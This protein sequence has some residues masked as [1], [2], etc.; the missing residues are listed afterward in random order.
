MAK[1]RR[2][3]LANEV[4]AGSTAEL[5]QLLPDPSKGE[6][7]KTP[8]F[9]AEL[10]RVAKNPLAILEANGEPAASGHQ[11]AATFNSRRDVSE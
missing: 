6:Q 10:A 7:R 5:A 11:R 4:L 1:G 2:S 3:G 9:G 8:D